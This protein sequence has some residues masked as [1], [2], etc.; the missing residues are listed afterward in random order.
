[1]SRKNLRKILYET[2][3]KHQN[4]PKV[5]IIKIAAKKAN[6]TISRIWYELEQR[7]I[8]SENNFEIIE[9]LKSKR[10]KPDKN[11]NQA[12]LQDSQK[13]IETIVENSNIEPVAETMLLEEK[14]NQE[15]PKISAKPKK[16]SKEK[17]ENL[18]IQR[19]WDTKKIAEKYQRKR[20]T[21]Y[22]WLKNYGIPTHRV[23]VRRP[24][25]LG[26]PSKEELYKEYIEEK[27]GISEIAK[28][29]SASK[30]TVRQWIKDYGIQLRSISEE[31]LKNK[32]LPTREE[33]EEL[34]VNKQI[35]MERISKM[36][37]IGRRVIKKLLNKF[38]IPIRSHEDSL[39]LTALKGKKLPSKEELIELYFN[40]KKSVFEIAKAYG[41]SCTPILR[42]FKKY[43]LKTRTLK[44]AWQFRIKKKQQADLEK[45]EEEKCKGLKGLVGLF[46][47]ALED[48]EAKETIN[49][50]TSGYLHKLR[51][52]YETLGEENIENEILLIA[53][54]DENKLEPLLLKCLYV[55][56]LKTETNPTEIDEG[57]GEF[58]VLQRFFFNEI[59]KLYLKYVAERKNNN[60][61]INSSS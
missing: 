10:G 14:K 13:N 47:Q 28:I 12:D 17:L 35:S 44:Q 34:Y 6:V 15:N 36:Y 7:R 52:L 55:A 16:P 53:K 2:F 11:F 8:I 50:I 46:V 38:E 25:A 22:F 20:I 18:Y 39:S 24:R 27:K 45:F 48:E 40:K 59:R 30:D 31:L 4:L 37:R 43:N 33:L 57:S 19:R 5:E 42:L 1:M 32:K 51:N 9:A 3:V 29:H 49:S 21:I 41:I 60:S 56:A 54:H 61:L 58:E 26:K 23:F